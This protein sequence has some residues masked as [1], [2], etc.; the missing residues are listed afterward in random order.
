M[1]VI[2]NVHGGCY[3]SINNICLELRLTSRCVVCTDSHQLSEV[4]HAHHAVIISSSSASERRTKMTTILTVSSFSCGRGN[5]SLSVFSFS[6]GRGHAKP[7]LSA[8][9][10]SS[11]ARVPS[12]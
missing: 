8:Y 1:Y 7:T 6:R 10:V 3:P 12:L 5:V 11:R 4:G 9:R 2:M